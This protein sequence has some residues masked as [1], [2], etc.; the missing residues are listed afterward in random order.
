MSD[1]GKVNIHG[2]EYETVASRV[3]KFRKEYGDMYSIVTYV[4][5]YH[6]ETVLMKAAIVRLE[7]DKV[8]ATGYAEENRGSSSIN[9]TSAL[10]NAETSA[11]GRALANF[12]MA[13]TEYASADEVASAI[14]QRQSPPKSS[15]AGPKPAAAV[16]ADSPATPIQK[17]QITALLRGAGVKDEN[18]ASVVM[19]SYGLDLKLLMAGD[20]AELIKLIK[21][22]PP[23]VES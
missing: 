23:E 12:G 16:S 5:E 6:G 4:L 14:G 17:G 8:I 9:M 20:A 1:S 3:Q 2:R 18:F 7:D 19:A 22:Q 11:I 10:E 21:A 13:G 15:P